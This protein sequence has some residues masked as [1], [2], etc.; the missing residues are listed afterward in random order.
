MDVIQID[1]FLIILLVASIADLLVP[2]IIATQYPGYNH[3][4]QTIST[5]G[6]SVSPVKKYQCL[7]LIIVGS[8]FIIFSVGQ[9]LLL[10]YMAWY[11]VLYILGIGVFGLGT[12]M[13]GIFPEDP[14]G[15]GESVSGKIHGISSG[16]GFIF[17][18]LNPLW[19]LWI[20]EFKSLRIINEIIFPLAVISFVLFIVSE[21][22][23]SGILKYTGFFQKII[24]IIL[25]SHLVINYMHLR[26]V[27]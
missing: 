16:M 17:L 5:L 10:R 1:L 22:K 4:S 3:F 18:I 9:G 26:I 27:I 14:L 12:I 15:A 6:T 20:Q 7:N 25:Y 8:L 24:M 19:A 23:S 21:K 2:A 11:H 13:A